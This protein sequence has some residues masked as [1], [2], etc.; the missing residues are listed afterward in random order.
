MAR[1]LYRCIFSDFFRVTGAIFNDVTIVV[2]E[3]RLNE[4]E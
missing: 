1:D 3:K 2:N 4:Y